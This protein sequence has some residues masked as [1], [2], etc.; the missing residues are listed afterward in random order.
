M[1]KQLLHAMFALVPLA[2]IG[3]PAA[4]AQA[5]TEAEVPI[6]SIGISASAR[7]DEGLS[8]DDNTGTF[9]YLTASGTSGN[10]TAFLGFI[11][12][13]D[14]GQIRFIKQFQDTDAVFSNNPD[15]IDLTILYTTDTGD[16]ATRNYIPV[17]GLSSSTGE[18]L[19]GAINPAAGSVTDEDNPAGAYT[20]TF[21]AV[22]NATGLGFA[23]G[24][25][26][27][28]PNTQIWT[29]YP[30]AEFQAFAPVPEPGALALIGLAG[31]A[32]ARR[33]R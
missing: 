7:G 26:A 20:L 8:I 27:S 21:D 28:D 25:S 15:Y 11:S 17:T 5:P 2:L 18:S 1:S 14:V 29:H 13:A 3:V 22:S 6:T 10:V 9:S 4:W 31:I 32:L 16:L 33:R 12:P 23:F 30:V 24:P 19:A